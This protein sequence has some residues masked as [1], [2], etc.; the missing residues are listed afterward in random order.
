MEL[1]DAISSFTWLTVAVSASK[2]RESEGLDPIVFDI[3]SISFV[4]HGIGERPGVFGWLIMRSLDGDSGRTSVDALT[5]ARSAL[6]VG[7][8]EDTA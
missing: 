5:F 8:Y 3:A 4:V 7:V 2:R 6:T 1:C